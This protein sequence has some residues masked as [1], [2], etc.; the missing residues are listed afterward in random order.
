MYLKPLWLAALLGAGLPAAAAADYQFH[1]PKS[2]L[3]G[4]AA[5]PTEPPAEPP[6]TE[7][8]APASP[9]LIG[10][11][12]NQIDL[13]GELLISGSAFDAALVA[14]FDGVEIP[15]AFHSDTAATVTLPAAWVTSA[16]EA[17]TLQV[18]NGDG[19]LSN[20]QTVNYIAPLP[21]V[22]S[23]DASEGFSSGGATVTLTG[24]DFRQG[25]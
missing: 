17:H 16:T 4:P 20:V 23:S 25:A 5:G 8:T 14:L 10:T 9:T 11:L 13:G 1:L 2:G 22:V 21:S 24:T 12:P 15:L 19:L 18:R 7:P 3:T 6:P